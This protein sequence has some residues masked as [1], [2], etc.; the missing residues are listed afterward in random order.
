MFDII[1]GSGP[2]ELHRDGQFHVQMFKNGSDTLGPAQ[3]Q[4][5]YNRAA[6]CDQIGAA[7]KRLKNMLSTSDAAVKDDRNTV[8]NSGSNGWEN[9]YGSR[10]A[11]KLSA[12]MVEDPDARRIDIAQGTL[13]KQLRYLEK[14]GM[15]SRMVY[16]ESVLRVE[17]ELTPIGRRFKRVLDAIE[18]WGSEYIDDL[19]QTQQ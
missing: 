8:I 18:E 5:V 4:A 13:S 12:A 16:T 14:E 6:D 11:I 7:R 9:F 15:I 3:I 17:Y 1:N 10:S 19:R 2:G